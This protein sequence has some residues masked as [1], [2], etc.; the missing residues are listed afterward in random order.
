MALDATPAGAASDSYLTVAAADAYAAA[1]L[2]RNREAWAAA[3]TDTK[4]RAL[5]RA[6]RDLSRVAGYTGPRY[7]E[8]QALIFPRLE[9]FDLAGDP[10]I[11]VTLE[12]ATYEQAAFLIR[13]A[14][15]IDDAASRRARGLANFAEPD[16]SGQL[17]ADPEYGSIAP[18]ALELVVEFTQ[19]SSIGWISTT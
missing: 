6:T 3:D 15:V 1:D 19:R 8:L 10:I 18:R 14:D 4:E 12:H 7:S 5:K 17:A 11:P 16:V 13:N 2:G 9:D